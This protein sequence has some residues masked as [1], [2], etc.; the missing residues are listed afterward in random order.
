VRFRWSR[1]QS[2]MMLELEQTTFE[3]LAQEA[4]S[5]NDLIPLGIAQP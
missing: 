2:Q 3:E 4:L 5:I 1:L